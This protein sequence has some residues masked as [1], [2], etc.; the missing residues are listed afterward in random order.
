MANTR[1]RAAAARNSESPG[2]A[3]P[4]YRRMKTAWRARFH[5][6]WVLVAEAEAA[7]GKRREDALAGAVKIVVETRG[8]RTTRSAFEQTKERLERAIKEQLA[9]DASERAPS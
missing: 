2:D 1:K 9:I 3:N 6:A 8:P 7:R 5:D 4:E